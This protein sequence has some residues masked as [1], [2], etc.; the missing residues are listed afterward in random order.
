MNQIELAMHNMLKES[1]LIR[2][3]HEIQRIRLKE[4]QKQKLELAANKWRM[5][6]KDTNMSYTYG[7]E[8]MDRLKTIQSKLGLEP[9]GKLGFATIAAIEEELGYKL[10]PEYF[11]N[12]EESP[13]IAIHLMQSPNFTKTSN[14]IAK[15]INPTH[16]CFHHSCGSTA[17]TISWCRNPASGVSYHYVIGLDGVVY[18]LVDPHYRAWHAGR[19]DINGNPGNDVSI[20]IAFSGDT[21]TRQLEDRELAA[22]KWLYIKLCDTFNKELFITD[23]RIICIPKGRKDDLSPTEFANLYLYIKGVKP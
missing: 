6:N 22:A 16:V 23:H 17:G 8:I 2:M 9:D 1:E 10:N 3:Q 21:N 14:G 19:S 11:D 5:I 4:I 15:I 13:Q 20:G 7:V 12:K 18:Q